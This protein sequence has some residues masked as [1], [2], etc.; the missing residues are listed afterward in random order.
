[1]ESTNCTAEIRTPSPWDFKGAALGITRTSYFRAFA[2]QSGPRGA[3]TDTLN[4]FYARHARLNAVP[5][6]FTATVIRNLAIPE[7][8][9]VFG[10]IML[11]IWKLRAAHPGLWVAILGIMLLS[12]FV[13]RESPGELGFRARALPHLVREF[14]PLLAVMTLA[15]LACGAALHS[16]RPIGW[17]G[18]ALA[19]AAYLPWGLLQQYILNGYFLRQFESSLSQRSSSLIAATLFSIV[20][21]PNPLLMCSALPGGYWSTQIYRRTRCLYL[22]GLLHGIAGFLLF[23]VVP[24]SISHHL[25]VGPAWFSW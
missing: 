18:A 11:Y 17:G 19:L 5:T 24:D 6:M 20:H 10:M 21:S 16:I 13:R 15:M 14:S 9:T 1:M 4:W 7:S 8:M 22:M 3:S 25:R 12:H 23:M 2:R